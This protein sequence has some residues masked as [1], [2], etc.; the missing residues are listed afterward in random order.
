M[1]CTIHGQ[2]KQ[3][4]ILQETSEHNTILK[5]DSPKSRTESKLGK[6]LYIRSNGA[7]RETYKLSLNYCATVSKKRMGSV[8]KTEQKSFET[9]FRVRT[10]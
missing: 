4:F 3:A 6:L 2:E 10:T 9:F 1:L 7:G 8:L 5:R